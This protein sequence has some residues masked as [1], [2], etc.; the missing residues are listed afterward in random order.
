[1]SDGT[2]DWVGPQHAGALLVIELN[3]LPHERQ[4]T[5]AATNIAHV[6]NRTNRFMGTILRIVATRVKNEKLTCYGTLPQE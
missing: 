2:Y 3:G 4:P 5:D 1:M 6:T